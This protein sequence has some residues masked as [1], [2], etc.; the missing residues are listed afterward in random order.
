MESKHY[1]RVI[2]RDEVLS[3]S[4]HLTGDAPILTQEERRHPVKFELIRPLE[5]DGAEHDFLIVKPTTFKQIKRFTKGATDTK[6]LRLISE[7]TGVSRNVLGMLL[8]ADFEKLKRLML[9]FNRTHF[10]RMQN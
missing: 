6:F 10:E 5:V 4:D 8:P 9:E 2:R 1:L 7:C 3:I